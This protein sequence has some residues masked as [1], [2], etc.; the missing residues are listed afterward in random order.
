MGDS[1]AGGARGPLFGETHPK[2]LAGLGLIDLEDIDAGVQ[3]MQR[4]AK[5][6]LRGVMI[7]ASPPEDRPYTH[8]G[9]DPFW[10][11]AQDLGLPVS[12]HI[13][14]GRGGP[15]VNLNK[16]LTSY[17]GQPYEIQMTLATLIFSGILER[18]P[19]LQIVSAE[20]DVS[21]LYH[22]MY[23]LDHAYDRFRHFEGVNLSMLP[24]EYVKRQLHASF[25]FEEVGMD[26]INRF[27]A[28]NIMWSSDYPHTDSTWPRSREFI[29][30]HF[31]GIPVDV[32]QKI[33]GANAARLYHLD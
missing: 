14:T 5:Q 25:Q 7:W 29:D 31:K 11:A 16:I 4:I 9:Y 23:R 26:L 28:G 6:G 2:R 32:T 17:M 3:E 1:R 15:R 20:N 8:P 21:W 13:L 24:S 33:I 19:K 18:F 30:G 12:F 22:F 27:G 10:A